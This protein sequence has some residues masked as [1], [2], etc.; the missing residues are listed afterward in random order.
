MQRYESSAH[1]SAD[2]AEQSGYQGEATPL[3]QPALRIQSRN[4]IRTNPGF[5][6]A[7]GMFRFFL[8]GWLIYLKCPSKLFF[9]QNLW[10][11]VCIKQKYVNYFNIF[12]QFL[13]REK[14]V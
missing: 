5:E 14:N 12:Q 1:G 13:L 2:S 8:K 7:W 4:Q 9:S 10:T 11:I 6:K 3:S